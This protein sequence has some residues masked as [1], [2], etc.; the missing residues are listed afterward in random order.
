[1][2]ESTVDGHPGRRWWPAAAAVAS[3]ILGV[4]MGSVAMAAMGPLLALVGHAG[5]VRSRRRRG[6][7]ERDAAVVAWIDAV[8]R[9][10]ATGA[11][12]GP[13]LGRHLPS[14]LRSEL[15]LDGVEHRTGRELAAELRPRADL[16]GLAGTTLDVLLEHGGPATPALVRLADTLRARAAV[17]R[18]RRAEAAHARASAQLVAAV[19]VA[20]VA[21]AS[22]V[23]P[24]LARFYASSTVGG[25]CLATA[26]VCA[27]VGWWWIEALTERSAR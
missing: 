21:G 27:A 11:A 18:R 22:L 2:S 26:A 1:M 16:L 12:L 19:P 8:A 20:F 7:D 3:V 5:R 17:R 13:S 23:D 14:T 6:R 25:V 24:S 4:R 10:L 9:D 15:G